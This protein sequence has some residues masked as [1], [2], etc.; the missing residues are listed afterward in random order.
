MKSFVIFVV[1][2]GIGISCL[3]GCSNCQ[4]PTAAPIEREVLLATSA[5][6]SQWTFGN[7]TG[8]PVCSPKQ[9][10][11]DQC[12]FSSFIED[13]N[14]SE[15]IGY[16]IYPTANLDLRSYKGVR[17]TGNIYA[18][19]FQGGKLMILAGLAWTSSG[20]FHDRSYYDLFL[21]HGASGTN[22]D[23]PFEAYIDFDERPYAK[24]GR[25]ELR[26]DTSASLDLPDPDRHVSNAV[27]ILSSVRFYGI[28]RV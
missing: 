25:L 26:V 20:Y 13:R 8:K 17:I 16:V 28:R 14:G 5:D 6:S 12:N 4:Y 3:A 9:W 24:Y 27:V 7:V 19:A 15:W 2:L 18:N 10:V 1:A 11:N 22:M 23:M 21:F